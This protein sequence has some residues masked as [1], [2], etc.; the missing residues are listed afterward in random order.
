MFSLFLK[1]LISD[2]IFEVGREAIALNIFFQIVIL[3]FWKN[4]AKWT[5]ARICQVNFHILFLLR[6]P[7]KKRCANH[8]N[9]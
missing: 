7:L 3:D 5:F 1:D 8:A 6:G 2:F 9:D 4:S